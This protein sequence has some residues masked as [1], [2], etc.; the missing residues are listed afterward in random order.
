M[1]KDKIKKI[2]AFI[3]MVNFFISNNNSFRTIQFKTWFFQKI[4]GFNRRVYW[5]VH[6]T[7]KVG[8]YRN[9]LID[10]GTTPGASPGCYIQGI[11]KI[12]FGKYIFIAPNVGIITANHDVYDLREHKKSFIEIGDYCWIGMNAVIL[13]GVKLGPHVVVGANSVVKESFKEGFCVIAG[14]PA[15]K[16]KDIDRSKV[17]NFD[18]SEERIGYMS[19]EKFEK[20]K[21]KHLNKDFF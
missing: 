16:I 20:F 7:S 21:R 13:P 17:I 15:K 6:F 5:P 11:G 12:K 2:I 9:V 3:P 8:G 19:V 18:Y 4:L 14:N 1:I 10:K